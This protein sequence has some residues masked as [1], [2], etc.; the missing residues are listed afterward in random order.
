MGW[1]CE[2]NVYHPSYVTLY[3]ICFAV[4][5]S[6]WCHPPCTSESLSE[7]NLQPLPTCSEKLDVTMMSEPK[8]KKLSKCLSPLISTSLCCHIRNAPLVH[9]YC[10]SGTMNCCIRNTKQTALSTVQPLAHHHH[11]SLLT[12]LGATKMGNTILGI[13]LFNNVKILPTCRCYGNPSTPGDTHT[14]TFRISAK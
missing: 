3:Q 7:P 4:V 9:R 14:V 11:L 8:W 1:L 2:G 12:L 5:T 6:I 13:S 10:H